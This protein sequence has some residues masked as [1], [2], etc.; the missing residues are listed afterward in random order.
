MTVYTGY[1]SDTPLA[2][3]CES[4]GMPSLWCECGLE[5]AADFAQLEDLRRHY[6][7]D[8]DTEPPVGLGVVD[9]ASQQRNHLR[10]RAACGVPKTERAVAAL[11]QLLSRADEV[12]WA[13]VVAALDEAAESLPP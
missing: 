7:P 3:D 6:A 12:G 11:H 5:E 9:D 13:A 4:C 8:P 2:A 10:Y 1:H